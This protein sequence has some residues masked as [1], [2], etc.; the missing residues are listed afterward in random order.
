[1]QPDH[2]P[3]L[4]GQPDF[5]H[6]NLAAEFQKSFFLLEAGHL[7]VLLFSITNCTKFSNSML[8]QTLTLAGK[9]DNLLDPALALHVASV[10]AMIPLLFCVSAFSQSAT[11]DSFLR[12]VHT[13]AD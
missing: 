4:R 8:L 11:K 5:S 6:T 1:M 7:S 3:A 13:F 9:V 2:T 12:L 10:L